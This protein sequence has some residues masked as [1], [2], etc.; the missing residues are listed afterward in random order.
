M[1]LCLFVC[2]FAGTKEYGGLNGIVDLREG[3]LNNYLLYYLLS[4][5]GI[6]LLVII[7]KG[8][9]Q[10]RILTY[11]GR[12]TLSIMIFHD[13]LK[14]VV[15]FGVSKIINVRIEQIRDSSF[16]T[17]IISCVI[18]ILIL[19]VKSILEKYMPWSLGKS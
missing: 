18:I 8:L 16:L 4:L 5:I 13:P 15:L 14:R 19:P 3:I 2:L 6:F 12:A 17:I 11:L 9:E 1:L 10:N 7:S